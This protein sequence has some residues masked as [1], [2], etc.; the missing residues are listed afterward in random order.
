MIFQIQDLDNIYIEKK[1][2]LNSTHGFYQKLYL[3]QN[4]NDNTINDYLENF[5]PTLLD[6][7]EKK[8]LKTFLTEQEILHAIMEQ[9]DNKSPGEDGIT[10]E[11]YKK[12]KL[13]IAPI[14]SEVY[15]NIYI[16]EN[17]TT[18]LQSGII[19]L[20]FKKGNPTNLKNWRPISL[21]N[22]D[23]KILTKVL[24][25][26]IQTVMD[27]LLDPLQKSNRKAMN[28]NWSNQKANP[29]LKTKTENK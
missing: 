29:A 10:S 17:L 20:L 4:I 28:R 19:R 23:Y 6:D 3:S 2:I 16:R 25:L 8:T 14:L 26:R 22:I 11:F 24:A 9:K 12:F 21:L 13:K 15:N 27:K 7:D 1:K 18:S 5:N